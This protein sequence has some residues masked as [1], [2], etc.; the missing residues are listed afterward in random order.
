MKKVLLIIIGILIIFLSGVLYLNWSEKEVS[1]KQ[2]APETLITNF[3]FYEEDCQVEEGYYCVKTIKD[4]SISG[5]EEDLVLKVTKSEFYIQGVVTLTDMAMTLYWGGNLIYTFNPDTI[6]TFELDDYNKEININILNNRYLAVEYIATPNATMV[7][8]KSHDV[9][10]ITNKQVVAQLGLGCTEIGSLN[11]AQFS[12][13]YYRIIDNS[14]FY[15]TLE[16][17]LL[18]PGNYILREIKGTFNNGVLEK[19]TITEY[20]NTNSIIVKDAS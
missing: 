8:E 16:A 18:V 14:I 9:I 10:D 13:D 11:G 19:E 2:V 4:V 20:T 12:G 5:V 17:D 6:A 1:E 3:D 7:S 15:Y